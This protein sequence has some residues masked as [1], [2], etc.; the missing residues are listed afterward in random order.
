M[1]HKQQL[2]KNIFDLKDKIIRMSLGYQVE[3]FVKLDL[4]IDQLKSLVIIEYHGKISFKD[5][6]Q[7]L[8]ITRANIT[9]IANR[10][11]RNGLVTSQ[12]N[13][14]DRRVQY[15][16]LTEK[17]QSILNNI[18]QIMVVNETKVLTAL[19]IEE[20]EALEKGFSAFV[21]SADDFIIREQ[22]KDENSQ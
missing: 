6:A 18:R 12:P 13:P 22:N 10:L 2:I 21:K 8:G 11:I 20:L 7:T 19:N 17:A 5:L 16:D 14:D 9:G 1:Q 15:L 4:T 3:N